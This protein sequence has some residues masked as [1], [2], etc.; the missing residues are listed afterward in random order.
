[1][2]AGGWLLGKLAQRAGLPRLVGE[3]AWG[4][5]LGPSL[6]GALAPAA[7]ARLFPATHPSDPRAIVVQIALLVFLFCVGA[8]LDIVRL[9]RLGPRIIWTSL[10]GMLLP[11]ALGVAAV[12]LLPGVWRVHGSRGLTTALF[13]G[14]A[15]S[16]SALPVIARILADLK[17]LATDIGLVVMSA[18]TIDDI[19]GWSIFAAI[20][21][22]GGRGS[23]SPVV[24][25]ATVVVLLVVALAIGRTGAL[26]RLL[27]RGGSVVLGAAGLALALGLS[28]LT[29]TVGVGAVFGAFLAGVLLAAEPGTDP[30][31]YRFLDRTTIL[32]FAPL[33]FVSTGM[34]IDLRHDFVWTLAL[35]TIAVATVG[36]VVGACAGAR[37]GGAPA[38]DSLAIGFGLN[39]RGAMGIILA[40]TALENGMVTRPVFVAIVTMAL[41]TSM[42]SGPAMKS[43]LGRQG[44]LNSTA[45]DSIRR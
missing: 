11:F 21:A 30:P 5:A 41:V 22:A 8:R 1:M 34:Q 20:L 12:L 9:D 23:G 25:V 18:A 42:I 10:G 7:A 4:I 13:V 6:F 26:R 43:T 28:A 2:L 45:P 17:L 36:K 35:L 44:P 37:L 16:I 14:T 19:A 24:A 39:A 38:R 3:M 40:T 32:V 33:Y 29:G 31:A 15:L 27:E